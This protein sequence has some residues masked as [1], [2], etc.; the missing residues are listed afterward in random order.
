MLIIMRGT[1]CSG[2][3]T[4]CKSYAEHNI[5]S[6]DKFRGML[7]GDVKDQSKNALVF[8][9]LRRTLEMRIQNGCLYTVVNATSLKF[10]D[11]KEYL[12]IAMK[13]SVPVKV[14]SIQPPSLEELK[15]R[16]IKRHAETGILIPDEVIER[17]YQTYQNTVDSFPE[18]LIAY[19]PSAKYR[20]LNQQYETVK[21]VG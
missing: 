12:D 21:K 14:I 18:S 1:T 4:F 6:S 3:D 11:I 15:Q 9:E 20:E 17:H 8:S 5:L 10:K 2:K 19:Y 13:Y 16:N 7:L